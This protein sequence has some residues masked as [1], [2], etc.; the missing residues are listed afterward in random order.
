MFSVSTKEFTMKLENFQ[1][2]PFKE[3]TKQLVN[4]V[5]TPTAFV[6]P[7]TL[8]VKK[9]TTTLAIKLKKSVVICVDSRATMGTFVSSNA[10][11]KL[12]PIYPST[13]GP[14][15]STSSDTKVAIV[16]TMAGGAADCLFWER[17]V[18]SEAK[19]RLLSGKKLTARIVSKMLCE[20]LERYKGRNLSVGS[21]ICGASE[22]EG[23]SLFC[24]DSDGGRVEGQVFSVGS[25]STFAYGVVDADL[26]KRLKGRPAN[27]KVYANILEE[28][29]QLEVI[30][31]AKRA[32]YFAT[33][34]DGASGG[35]IR[36]FVVEAGQW[37]P[38]WVDDMNVLTSNL[39]N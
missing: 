34:R 2:I 12:I 11:Q 32:L 22:C 5:L 3:R 28:M 29:G 18:S 38:V 21:L 24:V 16:G 39:K 17:L 37:N 36:A 23:A 10:V 6:Y 14:K 9:G 30:D 33:H 25:G 13:P 31:L 35:I 8:E 27:D 4:D 26:A 7:K 15:R 1:T 20:H 19:A